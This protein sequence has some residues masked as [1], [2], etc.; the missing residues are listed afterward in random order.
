M[1]SGCSIR[2]ISSP[3]SQSWR[4]EDKPSKGMK[5]AWVSCK[6]LMN[7]TVFLNWGLCHTPRPL[8]AYS[9]LALLLSKGLDAMTSRR[10]FQP[11]LSCNLMRSVEFT[12]LMLF[13]TTLVQ[14]FLPALKAV[15]GQQ[16]LSTCLE[17]PKAIM[18]FVEGNKNNHCLLIIYFPVLITKKN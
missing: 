5:S 14:G 2:C 16:S 1:F 4:Y 3:S 11:S 7:P 10:P 13:P 6:T 18:Q 9:A 8:E 15:S 12:G 17:S